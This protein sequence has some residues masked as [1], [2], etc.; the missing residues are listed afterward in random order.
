MAELLKALGYITGLIGKWGLGEADTS[1]RS[2]QAGFRLLLRLRQPDACPQLLSRLPLEKRGEG[3]DPRQRAA[4]EKRGRQEGRLRPRPV[5]QRRPWSSS[6]RTRPGRSFCTW[7]T[8]FRTPTTRR[9]RST[10]MEVPSDEPYSKEPWP[11]PQKNQAA[12]ITRMDTRH[13][14]HHAATAR[15][16][17]GREHHRL[18]HAAT[19]ARI[20]KAAA[21]RSSSAVPVRCAASSARSMKA[22]CACR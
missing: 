12:M 3:A 20:R 8:R 1:R 5:H 9:A 11:Q 22:G 2:Q 16:G 21:T 14:P 15:A 10:G 13:W 4:Q 18:L 17:A 19:T 6:R 7:P